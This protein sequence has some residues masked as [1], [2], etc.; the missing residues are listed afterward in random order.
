M[1]SWFRNRGHVVFKKTLTEYDFSKYQHLR[2]L[3]HSPAPQWAIV[4]S[5]AL[6]LVL[7]G[8]GLVGFSLTASA[9]TNCDPDVKNF[10]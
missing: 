10:V 8:Y 2:Q 5:L 1:R 3:W 4:L 7:P 6:E 9:T